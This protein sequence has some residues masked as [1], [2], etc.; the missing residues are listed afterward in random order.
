MR[1]LE[2]MAVRKR[3]EVTRDWRRSHKER[4]YDLH[5]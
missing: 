4:Q 3:E 5:L 1:V 2:N